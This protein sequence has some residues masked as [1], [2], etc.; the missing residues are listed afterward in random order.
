MAE[1]GGSSTYFLPRALQY[2]YNRLSSFSRQKVRISNTIGANQQFGPNETIVINL[3]DNSLVDLTTLCLRFT[4]GTATGAGAASARLPKHIE[5]LI[6]S[7]YVSINGVGVQTSFTQ[8]YQMWKILADLQGLGDKENIRRVVNNGVGAV[9]NGQVFDQN[10]SCAIY[11]W[12]GFLGTVQPQV[13]DTSILGQ[14]Q[15]QIRL[16]PASVISSIAAQNG[17]YTLQNVSASV[18]V[19]SLEDGV[20]YNLI[21]QR[22]ASGTPILMPF[23]N[24]QTVVAGQAVLPRVVNWSVATQSLDAIVATCFAQGNTSLY[25]PNTATAG[26]FTRGAANWTTSQFTVNGLSFPSWPLDAVDAFVDT[27]QGLGVAQDTLGQ[28]DSSLTSL[29]LYRNGFFAHVHNFNMHDA[30]DSRLVSG[31]NSNGQALQGTWELQGNTSIV[32]PVLWLMFT[33]MLKVNAGRVVEVIL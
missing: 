33:S 1:A 25:E 23:Q 22:L 28:T 10:V 7:I 32:A 15:L 29:A 27:L 20:F 31:I 21:Q 16:A 19:L 8:Y 24:C 26:T 18:D 4:A 11:S 5:S 3:P 9:P 30:K 2:Y 12:L 17:T 14:V 6:D 13:L